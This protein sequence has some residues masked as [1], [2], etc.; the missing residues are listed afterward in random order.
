MQNIKSL[1]FISGSF[2]PI[3]PFLTI[4]YMLHE[5]SCLRSCHNLEITFSC[6]LV[7]IKAEFS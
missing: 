5:A 2:V 7:T 1:T 3:A 6:G 4:L